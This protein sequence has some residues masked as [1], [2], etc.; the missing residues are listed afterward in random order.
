LLTI[1]KRS[2]LPSKPELPT[3]QPAGTSPLEFHPLADIFPLLEG[4]EFEELIAAPVRRGGVREPI[5][6]YQGKILDGRNR[7]R[8]A[9]AAGVHVQCASITATTLSDSSSRLISIAVTSPPRR[10]AT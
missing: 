4:A 7:Y 8:A 9:V 1:G 2:D 10:S 5:W 3:T 6:L